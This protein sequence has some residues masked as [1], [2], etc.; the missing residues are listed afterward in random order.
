MVVFYRLWLGVQ[1]CRQSVR[2]LP[3]Q[4]SETAPFST[5]TTALCAPSASV[6]TSPP[7]FYTPLGHPLH[8]ITR[9]HLFIRLTRLHACYVVVEVLETENPTE[10]TYHYHLLTGGSV[11]TGTEGRTEPNLASLDFRTF[12][13][14][15]DN[16]WA[17]G[18]VWQPTYT[19]STLKRPAAWE[20]ATTESKRPRLAG[21]QTTF[22]HRL[23][24]LVAMC[25]ANLPFVNLQNELTSMNI[26]HQ[27]LQLEGDNITLSVRLLRVPP[28]V[29][30]SEETRRALERGLLECTFRLQ[31]R[32]N[33]C[34]LVELVFAHC[35]LQSSSPREQGT[36]RHVY[37]SYETPPAEPVGC[38]RVI[39][40]FLADW[41]SIAQL[42]ESVLAFSRILHDSPMAFQQFAEVRS[43]SYKKIVFCYGHNKGSS[44]GVQ[45]LSGSGRFHLSL[46]TVGPNSGSSNCHSIIGHQLQEAF[47]RS[48]CIAQLLQILHDTQNPLNA[49]NKL[50]TVP[51]LGLTPRPNTPFQCFTILPQSPTHVRLAFRSTYCVDIHCKAR[52]TVAIRDGAYSLFDSSKIVEGFT[53]APG[54]KTFLNMFV[55]GGE[56]A[57]RRSVNEDDNP[58]SPIGADPLDPLL[59]P[60]AL[61]PP[62]GQQGFN[63]TPPSSGTHYP[64]ASP[65]TTYPTGVIPSPSMIPTPSPGNLLPAN[66]PSG[67]LRVPSPASF[68]PAPSPSSLAIHMSTPSSFASPHASVDPNSPYPTNMPMPSP[69]HRLA[70]WPGSPQLAGGPR[71]TAMT[72]SLSPAQAAIHSPLSDPTHSPRAGASLS[73]RKLPQ[74][75]WAGAIPSLLSHNA[76]HQLLCPSPTPAVLPSLAGSYLCSPLERFLGSVFMRR[77]LQRV[78]QQEE[79]LHLLSST[80]PGVITFKTE[81]LKCRVALNAQTFQTLQ[82]KATPEAEPW[83]PDELQVLEKFFETRV[84]GPPFKANTL[85][86]FAK[87]L[88]APTHILHDC[89]QIMRLELFPDQSLRWGVQFCLTIP[90]SAPP[91]APPGMPA[92]VLKSKML[93]F[94]QLTQR[95]GLP[96]PPPGSG[97][98]GSEAVSVIVPVVYDMATGSTQQAEIPRQPPGAGNISFLVS[99]A[100]RRFAELNPPHPGE[101]TIFAAVKD[102]M[103]NLVLPLPARA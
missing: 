72:S 29:E 40:M 13:D 49:I 22:N 100:L 103:T 19:S 35:P 6:C 82:L 47:N 96:A 56:E 55:D 7:P 94:L 57:R 45:W 74:R 102:L 16:P 41:A 59:L 67:G 64:L 89:V 37:L 44:I 65:P 8:N 78:I 24:H 38:H 36:V 68:A 75:S 80:E 39:E 73:S 2:H 61:P 101:C 70:T 17:Y 27:G 86:A 50:P 99:N 76:L 66:S 69:G 63:K 53:P 97:G 18:S 52:G 90:P 12:K 10:V 84:A 92:V 51:M 30:V 83:S 60:Q 20:L 25:D 26:P 32:N 54:L 5:T 58:P 11:V 95:I 1:R 79:A 71:H 14:D 88:G 93:F 62:T 85:N 3:T 98:V 23:A 34:W 43:Y 4:S 9:P 31:G 42:H 91:I 28:C 46:G 48:P 33:R 15:L 21:S 81:A 77:H 87:L